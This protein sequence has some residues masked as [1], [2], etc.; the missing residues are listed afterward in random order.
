LDA[1]NAAVLIIFLRIQRELI[2]MWLAREYG[3]G[4]T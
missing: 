2:E 1:V 4:R 3:L